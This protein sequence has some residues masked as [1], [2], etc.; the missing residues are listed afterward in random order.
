MT[1]T[2]LS[3]SDNED[4]RSK[5]S[6]VFEFINY[7][8]V[9]FS[10]FKSI[11]HEIKTNNNFLTALISFKDL[12]EQDKVIKLLNKAIPSLAVYLLRKEGEAIN[13]ITAPKGITGSLCYPV[14]YENLLSAIRQAELERR[15]RSNPNSFSISLTGDS[16]QIKKIE[17][18]VK[19]VAFTD[20]NVLLLG[21]S[22]TG[23]EVVARGIHKLSKRTDHPFVAI[24]CGAI[25]PE[26][27]ESELFG[28][29]KGA[30]S[31]AINTRRGRFELAENGTLFLDEIG[32]MPLNMQVKLLRV[33]QEKTFERVG[34]TKTL[35]TNVRLIAAT[36]QDLEKRIDEEKFRMDLFYR[37][38][39]FPIEL[40]PLR[41]RPGDI[42]LLVKE[43][44]IKMELN[45]RSPIEFDKS[46]IK[47]LS[48]HPL[49]GNVRELENL[50][51]RLAILYPGE[52]ITH[53]KLPQRYQ[54]QTAKI[55]QPIVNVHDQNNAE[56][57]SA[58]DINNNEN[59]NLK[60]YLTTIEKRIIHQALEESDWIV[61]KAAKSLSLQRTTLVEKIRKFDINN[62]I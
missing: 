8:I 28:H 35:T 23:K 11:Q 38:N 45:H 31:G 61:A 25:P 33:I 17:A 14:R 29:E 32:D 44:S 19:Q 22:G 6:T 13:P 46:A 42:A 27:L 41:E 9:H 7:D 4:I 24:N 40:A 37:L 20:A 30:F 18:L 60:Q 34:G 5:I 39:V 56:L 48:N 16:P 3:V 43:F 50:V 36:H 21:E 12:E 49:P 47:A 10:D 57:P 54:F 58:S 53:E 59:M 51:E 55:L 2:V 52:T 26:L 1:K 62:P 15:T